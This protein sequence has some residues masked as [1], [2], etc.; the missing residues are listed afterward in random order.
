M[1]KKKKNFIGIPVRRIKE[2]TRISLRNFDLA[3]LGYLLVVIACVLVGRMGEYDLGSSSVHGF[4][5]VF[6]LIPAYL[7]LEVLSIINCLGGFNWDFSGLEA[8]VLGGCNI[9]LSIAIWIYVRWQGRERGVPFVSAART[10]VLIF[11]FWGVFQ[12]GCCGALWL[13]R[14]GGFSSFNRHLLNPKTET[15]ANQSRLTDR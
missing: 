12:L 6:L 2:K 5:L 4:A 13:W 3:M 1:A 11:M 14:N 10:F 9:L 15:A 8:E 7:M